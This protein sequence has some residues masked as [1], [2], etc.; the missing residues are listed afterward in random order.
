MIALRHQTAPGAESHMENFA[1]GSPRLLTRIGAW[2]HQKPT[3]IQIL[4]YG[5]GGK[6][7]DP[8]IEAFLGMALTCIIF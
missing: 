4:L 2:V 8:A 5:I 1:Y 7:P 3:N 6:R